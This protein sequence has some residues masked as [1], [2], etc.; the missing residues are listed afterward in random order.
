MIICDNGLHLKS[1]YDEYECDE[2]PEVRIYWNAKKK[3]ELS[4]IQT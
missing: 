1:N 4:P 2:Y 3:S